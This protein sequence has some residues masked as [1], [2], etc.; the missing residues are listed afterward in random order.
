MDARRS[1]LCPTE[2]QFGIVTAS[3]T[4]AAAMLPYCALRPVSRLA[5]ASGEENAHTRRREDM[6][7][8]SFMTR[9]TR[10]CWV[11]ADLARAREPACRSGG[12]GREEQRSEKGH[13]RRWSGRQFAVLNGSL[14]AVDECK[15][16]RRGKVGLERMGTSSGVAATRALVSTTNK[17]A[18][19]EC[20]LFK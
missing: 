17:Q 6:V 3:L 20:G 7:S 5:F 19:F 13:R 2:C 12:G 8:N 9:S 4:F 16:W 10:L 1:A 11:V 14:N 18:R 15:R